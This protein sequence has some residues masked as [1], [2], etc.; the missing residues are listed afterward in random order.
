VSESTVA[1][2]GSGIAGTTIAYLLAAKGHDVVVFEKGP[3]YPY[4]HFQQ[5]HERR[6]LYRNPAYDAPRDLQHVTVSGDYPTSLDFERTM[7]VGGCCSVWGA[8]S[9]RMSP[10]DFGTRSRYG[11]GQDWPLTYDELESYYCDAERLL[12]V[13][14]T[15][16][17]NPFAPRRSRPYPLP[18][19]ALGY[20]D[21]ILADRLR[22]HGITLHTTPQAR[23]RVPYEKRPG[24]MN[25]GT[26]E[27]CPIGVRYSPNYHLDMAL[28]TGRCTIR[29]DTSVRRVIA[30]SSGRARALVYQPNDAAGEQEHSAKVIVI[31]AGTFE[32]VRLLLLSARERQPDGIQLGEHVGQ[33]LLFHHAWKGRMHYDFLQRP[34]AVGPHTGLSYQF[35]APA[36]RGKHGGALVEMSLDES[37]YLDQLE[38]LDESAAGEIVGLLKESRR[39]RVINLQAESIPTPQKYVTLSRERDRFGDPFAH[40]HYES[41]AFDHESYRFVRQI[42]DKFVAGTKADGGEFDRMEAYQTS[43]H[44]MGGC[45]MG[46]DIRNSAVDPFGKIHGTSNLFVIGGSNFAGSSA[47]HPTLTIAALAIRTADYIINRLL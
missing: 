20:D 21:R 13:S 15:D 6:Y 12:G 22:L 39:W 40:V 26:C 45:R 19:F 3:A 23:T 7:H 35:R 8:V 46:S 1:V 2:V 10:E 36:T 34:G 25:F 27:A 37:T 42:F 30:D 18:P 29:T 9:L 41:A 31:A 47:V 4:P 16:T 43:G 5:F 28:G 38:S 44:H 32:A 24:C 17:D 14:G 11:F 33:H